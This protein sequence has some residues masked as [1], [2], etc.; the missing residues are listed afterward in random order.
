VVSLWTEYDEGLGHDAEKTLV[1]ASPDQARQIA[2]A[3]TAEADC[4]DSN[5]ERVEK[6]PASGKGN[7]DG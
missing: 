3:L 6:L 1:C 7:Q 2:V 5:N 4:A